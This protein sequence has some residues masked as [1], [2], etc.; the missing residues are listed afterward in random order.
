MKFGELRERCQARAYLLEITRKG[1]KTE[2]LE[3][4]LD[5]SVEPKRKLSKWD[6]AEVSGFRPTITKWPVGY[7]NTLEVFLDA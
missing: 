1:G 5:Y 2:S 7:V 3:I 6:G 4:S